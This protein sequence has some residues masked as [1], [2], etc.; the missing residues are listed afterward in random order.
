[1]LV[2]ISLLSNH[3]TFSKLCQGFVNPEYVIFLTFVK[4]SQKFHHFV[5]KIRN[6]IFLSIVS[7]VNFM[8]YLWLTA[9]SIPKKHKKINH[10]SCQN[11][12][13]IFFRKSLLK[14]ENSAYILKRKASQG[15]NLCSIRPAT[16]QLCSERIF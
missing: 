8:S 7:M 9:F 12:E 5:I 16:E 6:N 11:Y 3:T 2:Y 13:Q 15:V 14:S 4:N 10:F 1:M